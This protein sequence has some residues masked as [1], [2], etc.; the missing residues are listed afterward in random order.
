M[1]IQDWKQLAHQATALISR[2]ARE[3]LAAGRPR[4]AEARPVDRPPQDEPGIESRPGPD[5]T[6][7]SVSTEPD[8]L[9]PGTHQAQLAADPLV[10]VS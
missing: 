9:P 1:L 7:E 3:G 10:E 8:H 6:I 4:M 2:Y 5:E